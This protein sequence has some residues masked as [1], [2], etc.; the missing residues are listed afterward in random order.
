MLDVKKLFPFAVVT[1]LAWAAFAQDASEG[2]SQYSPCEQ[3]CV[4]TENACYER[5]PSNDEDESCADDCYSASDACLNR[6][7]E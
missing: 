7:S 1:L 4:D 6:C 2:D 3:A 5:C